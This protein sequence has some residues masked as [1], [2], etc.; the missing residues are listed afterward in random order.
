MTV[1][2]DE[3]AVEADVAGLEGRDHLEFRRQEVFLDDAVLLVQDLHDV[4]LDEFGLLLAFERQGADED[5]QVLALDGVGQRALL[6]LLREVR[7][8][9]GDDE[10]R[11]AL[12]LAD[13]DGDR[14]AVALDDDAVEGQRD[15]GP[16]VL[17]D[18]AVVVGLEEREFIL[19]IKRVRL[20]VE[21]RGVD[22]GR[23]DAQTLV[24]GLFAEDRQDDALVP[25]DAVDAVAGFVSFGLVE[26]G[27]PSLLGLGLEERGDLPLGLVVRHELFVAFREDV[28]LREQVF[29]HDRRHVFRR[30]EEFF[31]SFCFAI[32]CHGIHTFYHRP[33]PA[34]YVRDW[35][36]LAKEPLKRSKKLSRS[37]TT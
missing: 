27:V 11:V 7:K 9:V 3:R 16:L 19:L 30:V 29:F 10:L 6:L 15:G 14:G 37:G 22:V 20:E 17:L 28:R 4:E 2:G 25:V 23:R 31:Q 35:S 26:L 8:K 34:R 33:A 1:G 32:F 24:Q 12:V 18:A 21:A 13:V 5:V 36:L